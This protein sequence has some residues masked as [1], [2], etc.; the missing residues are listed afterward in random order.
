VASSAHGVASSDVFCTALKRAVTV[1]QRQSD[2]KG[3]GK[4]DRQTQDVL[5]AGL[6]V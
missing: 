1:F 4:F 3:S 5:A 2:L 6:P